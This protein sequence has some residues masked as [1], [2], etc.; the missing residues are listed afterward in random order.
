MVIYSNVFFQCALLSV[1]A[2]DMKMKLEKE[3]KKSEKG[4]FDGKKCTQL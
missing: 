3:G 2:A 1:H 4:A